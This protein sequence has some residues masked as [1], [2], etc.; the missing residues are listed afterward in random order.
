MSFL[1]RLLGGP[2]N[3]FELMQQH[4]INGLLA[5]LGDTLPWVRRD[6]AQ[7]LGNLGEPQFRE[8][9]TAALNDNDA[10]VRH[11]AQDAIAKLHTY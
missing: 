2:P 5:A 10:E 9:L 7:S 8:P 11:A 6:A 1:K 3:T 4:D